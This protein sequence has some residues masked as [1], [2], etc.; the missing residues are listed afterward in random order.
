MPR[1]NAGGVGDLHV[2]VQLWTPDTVSPEEETI[3]KQL[4]T[5]ERRPPESRE[6]GFW[7]K[8]RERLGA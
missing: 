2:R 5:F 4:A 3:L 7:A 6:K 1:V 8:M